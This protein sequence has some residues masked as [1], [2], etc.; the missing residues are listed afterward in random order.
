M[1]T[2]LPISASPG[3]VD[4]LLAREFPLEESVLYLNHA[5]VAPLPRRAGTALARFADQAVRR[6]AAD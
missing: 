4:A 3:D 5:G 6:G 1:D 2:A